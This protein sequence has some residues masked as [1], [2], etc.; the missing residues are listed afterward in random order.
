M[1]PFND[2]SMKASGPGILIDYYNHRI[3]RITYKKGALIHKILHL[4]KKDNDDVFYKGLPTKV[5]GVKHEQAFELT[6]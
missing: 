3:Y 2:G 1:I 4:D 6:F 5:L